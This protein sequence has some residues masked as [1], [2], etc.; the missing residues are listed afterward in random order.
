MTDETASDRS[1]PLYHPD[2]DGLIV[3]YAGELEIMAD[4]D[5]LGAVTGQLE[6]Q[7]SPRTSFRAHFAGPLAELGSASWL[8][9]GGRERTVTI[10]KGASLDP[11]AEPLPMERL[12]DHAWLDDD[13][14]VD[15]I[16]AGELG[17]A[18]R[19]LFHFSSGF[20]PEFRVRAGGSERVAFALPG[21]SLVVVPTGAEAADERDFGGV[22]EAV[23]DEEPSIEAIEKLRDRLYVLLSFVAGREIGIAP[24]CGLDA[25]GVVAWAEWGAPRLRHGP[26]SAWW[27]PPL[28]A[29]AVLRDLAGGVGEIAADPALE[30]VT[31]RAVDHLLAAD[32]TETLDVRIPVACSGLELLS[33]AVLRRHGWLGQDSFQQL[34]AAARVRLLLQWAEVPIALPDH[35]AALIARRDHLQQAEWEAPEVL[36]NVRNGLIHPP[37]R[38]TDP[39]WPNLDEMVECWQFATWALQLVVLRLFGYADNYWSR[40]RLGRSSL[41]LEPV[42]WAGSDTTA[43]GS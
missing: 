21:W 42:P 32:S 3:V 4:A 16:T 28:I 1:S 25:E 13:I 18:E 40:L 19:F 38:L 41:G 5:Q 23:P 37:R 33:W 2:E 27:C 17:Q 39:E 14:W 30:Q 36:F 15:G 20:Q 35:F 22:V 34:T 31:H 11:P 9:A 7:L 43:G 12:E 6:L 10:P 24:V 29:P 26:A 8:S